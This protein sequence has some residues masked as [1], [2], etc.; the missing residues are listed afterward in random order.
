[1]PGQL[2]G[3]ARVGRC[4]ELREELALAFAMGTHEGLGG[5]CS[6]AAAGG[7]GDGPGKGYLYSEMPWE[8]V[9]DIGVY[10]IL[11][12]YIRTSSNHCET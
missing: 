1:V 4:H 9:R 2:R 5:G 3:S 6:V 7:G 12:N 11:R 8:L 10:C